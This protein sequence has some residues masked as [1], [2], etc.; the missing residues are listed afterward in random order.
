MSNEPENDSVRDPRAVRPPGPA[1]VDVL[2]VGAHPDDLEIFAGGTLAAFRR[3]GARIHL[4]HLTRGELG[5]RGTAETRRAEAHA[6]ARELDASVEI[7]DLGDGA[8]RDDDRGRRA[9]VGAIRG[10]RPR[11]L[12]GPYPFDD[13][14]DHEATGQLVQAA[15]FFANVANY[16][17]EAGPRHRLA[18]TWSYFSH[19]LA[20]PSFVVRL[21]PGDVERM[22]RAVRRYGSQ[23]HDPGSG[24]PETRLSRAGYLDTLVARRRHFGA[25]VGAEFGEP[26]WTKAP[27]A[28]TD[29]MDLL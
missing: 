8:L 15:A 24:D 26:F 28:I 12:L 16:A 27:L 19:H 23:F 2:A 10:H 13:H 4:L 1:T 6:A 3:R 18:A 20:A 5:T 9:L 21:E 17:P 29:P 22:M 11:V 7:L 14:P 25:L